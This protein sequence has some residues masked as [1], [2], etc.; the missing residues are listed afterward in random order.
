MTVKRRS[1]VPVILL[2]IA[3]VALTSRPAHSAPNVQDITITKTTDTT[4]PLIG[5]VFDSVTGEIVDISATLHVVASV[6]F[7]PSDPSG[8]NT[9]SGVTN[10]EASY[11]ATGRT[12]KAVYRLAA[13][14]AYPDAPCP[15]PGASDRAILFNLFPVAGCEG[16][17]DC[18]GQIFP[19]ILWQRITVDASGALTDYQ[20]LF[21]TSTSCDPFVPHIVPC[22]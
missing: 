3:M 14:T 12:T 16:L 9:C 7:D 10:V 17:P 21:G 8:N 20:A 19:A 1:F 15:V 18:G 11:S 22:S 13:N 5:S 2:A 6:S 4:A